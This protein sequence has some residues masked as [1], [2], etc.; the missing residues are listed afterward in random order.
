MVVEGEVMREDKQ[1]WSKEKLFPFHLQLFASG[2][3][4]DSCHGC[5]IFKSPTSMP[6]T[7]SM[8]F[9]PPRVWA[10][11]ASINPKK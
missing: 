3:E 9:V 8:L 10:G 6:K 1:R 7:V 11:R 4:N 5:F 2:Q